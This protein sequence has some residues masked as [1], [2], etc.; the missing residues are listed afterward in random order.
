M[1]FKNFLQIIILSFYSMPLYICVAEKWRHWGLFFLLKISMLLAILTSVFLFFTILFFDLDK[2]FAPILDKIPDINIKNYK[3]Y[4]NDQSINM[5]IRLK[6]NNNELMIID[7]NIED[8]DQYKQ[9]SLILTKDRLSLNFI[10]SSNNLAIKYVDLKI[11]QLNS[12][13]ILEFAKELK[14]KIL[15]GITFA[16]FPLLS[17]IYFFISLLKNLFYASVAG[18]LIKFSNIQLNFKQLLRISIV[19]STAS[20]IAG[21]LIFIAIGSQFFSTAQLLIDIICISYYTWAI[22]TIS[23][24][25][26]IK[27]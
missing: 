7:L 21:I 17:L 3:A 23:K 10:D 12:N 26:S 11:T 8:A 25:T 4:I 16:S 14:N 2:N 27:P 13:T 15:V 1:T 20:N 6:S 22:I 19:S 5:P 24:H 9:N 18:V